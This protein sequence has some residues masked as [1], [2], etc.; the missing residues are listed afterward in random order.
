MRPLGPPWGPLGPHGSPWGPLG[1]SIFWR[2]PLRKTGFGLRN[3][4]LGFKIVKKKVEIEGARPPQLDCHRNSAQ[5]P[6]M[7]VQNGGMATHLAKNWHHLGSVW[8]PGLASTP[9]A[10][11][12]GAQAA[13]LR[14]PPHLHFKGPLPLLRKHSFESP[15][16]DNRRGRS[17]T[18][19]LTR[20]MT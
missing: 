18:D 3:W 9:W 4:I 15:G 5:N 17:R 1:P 2:D 7:D 19:D 20:P 6:S 10:G 8:V 13:L 16:E 11:G 14:A 12:Y